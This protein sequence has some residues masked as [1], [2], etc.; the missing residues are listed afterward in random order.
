MSEGPEERTG[1]NPDWL[2]AGVEM[3]WAIAGADAT[4]ERLEEAGFAVVREWTVGEDLA[5]DGARWVLLVARLGEWVPVGGGPPLGDAHSSSSA[6]S[7][8]DWA[9]ARCWATVE[10]PTSRAAAT[11]PSVS[12]SGA[13]NVRRTRPSSAATSRTGHPVLSGTAGPAPRG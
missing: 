7:S 4:R 9:A 6:S 13:T 8:V 10:V 11:S 12:T 1:T 2:D 3:R 5:D